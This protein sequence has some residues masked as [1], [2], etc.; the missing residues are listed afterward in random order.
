MPPLVQLRKPSR[1][2]RGAPAFAKRARAVF[3]RTRL[4]VGTSINQ[5][6]HFM[7]LAAALRQEGLAASRILDCEPFQLTDREVLDRLAEAPFDIVAFSAMTVDIPAVARLSAKVRERFPDAWI[8]CGG[9]HASGAPA[10]T[11]RALPAVDAVIKGEGEWTAVDLCRRFLSGSRDPAG[12]LGVWYRGADGS[13]IENADRPVEEDLDR[14]PMPA[15]DLIDVPAYYRRVRRMGVLYKRPAYM[16]LF[17]SR[18]CP[19]RCNYCHATFGKKFQA[20]SP[21][22]V[23]DEMGHLIARY[24]VHDFSVLD[25]IFNLDK[26]RMM[27]ICE[28]I[29]RR[30]YAVHLSFPNGIRGDRFDYEGLKALR[31]AGGWRLNFAPESTSERIQEMIRKH[32]DM[33][34]LERSIHDAADL[35]FL[36]QGNFMLGFPTETFEEMRATVDWSLRSRLHL[37]NYFR[38]IPLV[39]TPM[40]DVI[41]ETAKNAAADPTQHD[42]NHTSINMTGVPQETIEELRRHAY[43]AFHGDPRRLARLLRVTPKHPTLLPLYAEDAVARLGAGLTSGNLYG[44]LKRRLWGDTA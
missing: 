4:G 29:L 21:E 13:I 18:A 30:G 20:H 17:T 24:G 44:R 2:D 33:D 31:M 41:D 32:N 3:I 43:R 22:R 14:I 39:G 5:P 23:L 25:D 36:T 37:A 26:K 12:V 40:N 15:Y 7:Y 19:Y 10:E 35:G 8:W 28:G 42:I 38:V 11:L 34:K 16:S 6:L 9:S 1:L 27:S